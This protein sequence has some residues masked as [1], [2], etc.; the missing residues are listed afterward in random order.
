MRLER[1]DLTRY[2]RFTDR[3]LVFAPPAP[4]APDLHIIYGPNE[5]GKS[6][7]FSAWLDLLFGIPMRTRY[8]FLHPGPTMQIGAGLSHTGAALDVRRLKRNSASLVDRHDAGLPEAALQAMLGGLSRDGYS[9]MF[10]LDDE[11]L[12]KGGDSILANR[13]DLGEML[14]S[15]SAGLSGLAPQLESLRADLDGFH[16]SG[17]R[18]GW[19]YDAKKQLADLDK[20]RRETEVSA[21]ALQK[22]LREAQAAEEVWRDARGREEAAQADLDRLQELAGTLPLLA[23]LS[24]LEDR[25]GPL[26][27]LPDASPEVQERFAQIEDD[28][29]DLTN[30]RRDRALRLQGLEESRAA[31]AADP[32]TLGQATAIEA[33][34]ALRSEH[35]TAVKDLP[36]RRSEVEEADARVRALLAQLGQ[37]GARAEDLCLP[38]ARISALRALLTVR[39][40]L[41]G[42]AT[43]AAQETK[44]AAA[45]LEREHERLGDPGPAEDEAALAAL[46]A[47]LRAQDPADALA[48]AMRDRDQARSRQDSA[49]A[50]LTPWTG[51]GDALATLAV[52]PGW[53]VGEWEKGQETARQQELDARRDAG[54]QRE[55][56]SRLQSEAAGRGAAQAASGMTLADAASAR[57][58]REALWATH[59]TELSATSAHRFE[60][61]LREDDRISALLAE[62]MAAA[63]REAL[64]LAA[65]DI[66]AARLEGA[67]ARL[68]A[69]LKAQRGIEA[70]IAAASAELGLPGGT[71]SDLKSWLDLRI[72]ALT[73]R[74]ALRD[75]ETTVGRGKEAQDAAIRSLGAAL[76]KPASDPPETFEI[77]LASAVARVDA[78]ERRREARQR[79]AMLASD[80]RERRQAQLDAETAFGAWQQDWKTA[81]HDSILAGYA[82]TDEGLGTVLDLLDRLGSEYQTAAGLTDR[83]RKME[84][85]QRRFLEAKAAVLTVLSADDDMSWTEVLA[86][87]RRAQDAVRDDETLARQIAQEQQQDADDRRMLEARDV[88]AAAIGASLGWTEADGS[89]SDYLARCRESTTLRQSIDALRNDL[90]DRPEPVEGED[91]GTIRQRAAD[92]KAELQ[93]LRND[94]EMRLATHL[95][96]KRRIEDVGGD[97]VL[98]RIAITRENLL[99]D[100]RERTEAHL[101]R[102]LGLIAFEAGL[103]RYRDQHRS[104]M[105]TRASKA[106]SRLSQGA[107][108]GL[109]AQPDGAQEVLVA[110]S[111]GGGA[112]LAV[113]LSKGTRFQLYLALRIAGYHE[114]AHSRPTVPFIADDIM[115]T[116]DDARSAAAFTLLA[117]MSQIGQVI[118]LTHHRHLCDIAISVCPDA[119]II[120]L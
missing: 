90:R 68:D 73:E 18:S 3:S 89:L 115:E 28:R 5:A 11:T 49:L 48:R 70:E 84:A 98:A 37:H 112:K 17:K 43:T 7:L 25:L 39:S 61:A 27:L 105:L 77:L 96:A 22:L 23:Q 34:E 15:A 92:L 106:F 45:L 55:E 120:D 36:R 117:E 83:I 88:D 63:R 102:R 31:L 85:N 42:T 75:A 10:S 72:A 33:A 51:D 95:E 86:R 110:L 12:E 54:V 50:T 76:R 14:F 16:R 47:R 87:L 81:S 30:R 108:S 1:L 101:A 53:Q 58:S 29:R 103:R 65:Q 66:A 62:A 9:A 60:Q 40:G 41:S 67:E 26:Q 24:G 35:D 64:D 94:T 38:N 4:G 111:A 21:G 79:L 20:Q 8:D 78:A 100:M 56:L 116:F 109:A 59:L 91:S 44:K 119:K 118:Y 52:P 113:D 6:T 82:E 107:Y 2:G 71:L 69:A 13:G 97:D 104:A 114:L 32:D 46:L 19:L 93:I 74:T 80:L 57:S 99:L